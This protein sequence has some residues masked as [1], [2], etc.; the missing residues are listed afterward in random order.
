MFVYYLELFFAILFELLGTNLMKFSAGFTK[1]WFSLGTLA[2]Y[3]LCFYFL[4][5]C[6]Q[7]I[8]LNIAYATWGG[9]GIVLAAI[10]SFVIFKENISM[11]QGLGITLIVIGVVVTNL[12]GGH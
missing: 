9:A 5:L 1:L 10:V 7:G 8:K 6:L 2:Y 11:M 12:S 3:A 4:S